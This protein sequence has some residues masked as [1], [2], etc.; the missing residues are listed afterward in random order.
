MGLTGFMMWNPLATVKLFPGEFIPAS[1]A[2]HGA[3][4]VLAVLAIIVWH[5]YGVHL[6]RFNKS[7]WTGQLK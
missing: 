4:A 6:Q 2:A 1:K 5:M 7:M 3:E